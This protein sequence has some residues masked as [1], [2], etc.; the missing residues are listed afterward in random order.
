LRDPI[1]AR[2]GK[3]QCL[4]KLAD[5]IEIE[6]AGYVVSA[7]TDSVQA[8]AEFRADPLHFDLVITDLTMPH[9]TGDKLARELLKLRPDL[10]II[11]TTG[12]GNGSTSEYLFW[13]P[14]NE[15]YLLHVGCGGSPAK[16]STATNADGNSDFRQPT[17]GLILLA[18]FATAS[19]RCVPASATRPTMVL[20]ISAAA[21]CST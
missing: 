8:L 21:P 16:W 6:R 18:G 3:P 9:L 1:E 14:V 2:V 7:C 17:Y 10:P 15:P 4:L 19:M 11:L 20:R 5:L 13:L 12:L